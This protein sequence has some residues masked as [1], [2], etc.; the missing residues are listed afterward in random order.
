MLL[1]LQLDVELHSIRL[2]LAETLHHVNNGNNK[3]QQNEKCHLVK[4]R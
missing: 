3:K 4:F 2:L 1:C